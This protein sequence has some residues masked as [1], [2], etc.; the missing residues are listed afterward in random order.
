MLTYN[1]GASDKE[2]TEMPDLK[3]AVV[4]GGGGGIG[5]AT[6]LAL[7]S[8]FDKVAILDLDITNGEVTAGDVEN[9]GAESLFVKTDV[10]DIASVNDAIAQAVRWGGCLDSLVNAAGWNVHSFFLEQEPDV[11]RRI[12]DVNLLGN[13]YVA[14]AALEVMVA[15]RRGSIVL[16]ASDA[17]RVGTNGETVYAA[18]KGGVIALTKSLAREVTRFG[19]RINCVSPGATDTPMLQSAVEHQP[20]IVGKMTAAIPMKRIAQ[21]EEQAAAI[22]F[23]L[24]EEASYITGQTLSVNG[25]LNML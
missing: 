18:A 16:V 13:I 1:Q 20:T 4:V 15:Q 17:G 6:A 2:E 9:L 5:R 11:W 22:R 3:V 10:T 8:S 7:A 24:S 19:V 25:G 14:R 23:L 21:P 12:V